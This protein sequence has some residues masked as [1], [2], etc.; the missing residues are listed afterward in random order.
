[1]EVHACEMHACEMHAYEMHA[2]GM[3][4]YDR[5]YLSRRARIMSPADKPSN[6]VPRYIPK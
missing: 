4:A 2:Y 5:P 3:H 1:M 6:Y